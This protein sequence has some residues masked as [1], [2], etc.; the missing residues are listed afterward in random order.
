MTNKEVIARLKQKNWYVKCQNK[1]DAGLVLQACD[2]AGIKWLSGEK[3][4]AWDFDGSYPLYID[5]CNAISGITG[6]LT[7]SYTG[8]CTDITDWFFN[9]I[10]NN[11]DNGK[12]TPQNTEQ[13]H[14]VQILLAKM[15]GIPVEFW[16]DFDQ[17]WD[18]SNSDSISISVKYRIKSKPT[19]IP[20]SRKTWKKITKEFRFIVMDKNEHFY[21]CKKAPKRVD[22][23]W[24]LSEVEHIKSP[25]VFNS[26]GIDWRTSLTERP[27][28]V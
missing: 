2:D 3:A 25:L 28:G 18:D 13:E 4:T 9:A 8:N 17:I 1:Q 20:V 22:G 11:D 24:L 10:K 21:H 12:L 16:Y 19:P 7:G 15:Q 6:N 5:F 26:D 23:E 27:E 14:Y